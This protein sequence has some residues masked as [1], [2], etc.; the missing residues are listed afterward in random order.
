MIDLYNMFRIAGI[1][2]ILKYGICE[3][4][5]TTSSHHVACMTCCNII[6]PCIILVGNQLDAQF[7]YDMFISILYMFQATMYSSSGGQLY[8]YN[9]WVI[10]LKT[11]VWSKI[12]EIT[13]IHSGCIVHKTL[14]INDKIYFS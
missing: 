13:R 11:S 3:S 9:F 4:N 1:T 8:E 12:T 10:T 2:V 7:F 6:L 14:T 5:Q